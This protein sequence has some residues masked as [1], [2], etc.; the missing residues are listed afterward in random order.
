M[1]KVEDNT[2]KNM[3]VQNNVERMLKSW[4]VLETLEETF[5]QTYQMDWVTIV[6]FYLKNQDA[7]SESCNTYRAL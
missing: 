6:T 5:I 4:I 2:E 7:Q 3:G 1:V